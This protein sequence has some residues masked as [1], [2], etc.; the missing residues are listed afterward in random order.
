MG[1]PSPLTFSLNNINNFISEQRNFTE[2][3]MARREEWYAY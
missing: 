3:L 2:D 1:S